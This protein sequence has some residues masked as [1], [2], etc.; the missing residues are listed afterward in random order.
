MRLLPAI[1]SHAFG[2]SSAALI[3]ALLLC[4]AIITLGAPRTHSL[5]VHAV[6]WAL[7][8][9]FS[10]F[11]K[12]ERAGNS[13]S[14]GRKQCWAAGG[15]LVLAQVCDR[16]AGGRV[17]TWW[18]R[19]R[20]SAVILGTWTHSNLPQAITP[21]ALVA[22]RWLDQDDSNSQPH[23]L[24]SPIDKEKLPN[25]FAKVLLVIITVFSV[26]ALSP[27]YMGTSAFALCLCNILLTSLAYS[28]LED[29][30]NSS[31]PGLY[32][33]ANGHASPN[34][35][36]SP[37]RLHTPTNSTQAATQ[38]LSATIAVGCA[39]ASILLEKHG[40]DGLTYRRELSFME[41][42][43]K[44]DMRQLDF[45]QGFSMCLVGALK[46]YLTISAVSQKPSIRS[47]TVLV[48]VRCYCF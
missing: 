46:G 31:D 3:A 39:V 27:S 9:L 33:T 15:L 12:Y 11:N 10:V 30:I 18:I 8:W 36:S 29:V 7:V 6:S 22:I 19:V 16:V 47:R 13:R 43:W 25:R 35:L 4:N 40:V 32:D 38:N 5:L 23:V 28:L 24:T 37:R 48:L 41:G 14:R 42:S 21:C 2:S 17:E 20:A 34:D 1:N 26:S 44:R 45:G